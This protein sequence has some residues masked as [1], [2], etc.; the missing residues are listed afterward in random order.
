MV[1]FSKYKAMLEAKKLGLK[2]VH[3][4]P[5]GGFKPGKTEEAYR[6][7]K[8]KTKDPKYGLARVR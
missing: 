2:T 6:N 3:K 8:R 4:T 5:D 7:A 1:K